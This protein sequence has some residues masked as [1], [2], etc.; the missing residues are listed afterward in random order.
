MGTLVSRCTS[1]NFFLISRANDFESFEFAF[2]ALRQVRTL[3]RHSEFRYNCNAID[4]IW[5]CKW[6]NS[7][8]FVIGICE[9]F[10]IDWMQI[11]IVVHFRT[12][13][14]I[15][16]KFFL[17]KRD[18]GIQIIDRTIEP[19]LKSYYKIKNSLFC[20]VNS[21]FILYQPNRLECWERQIDSA[22]EFSLC[23]DFCNLLKKRD[24]L[25]KFDYILLNFFFRRSLWGLDSN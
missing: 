25:Q 1:S 22:Y 18:F 3:T 4:W 5:N 7:H 19:T 14:C 11:R 17:C 24:L 23:I 16:L 21:L 13:R 10:V 12:F 20:F 6:S 9:C 8:C 15:V 2:S